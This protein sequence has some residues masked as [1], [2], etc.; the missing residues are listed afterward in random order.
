MKPNVNN[1]FGAF[2]A[3]FVV[4]V[5]AGTYCQDFDHNKRGRAGNLTHVAFEVVELIF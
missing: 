5:V 1:L 3:T 2:E 4:V